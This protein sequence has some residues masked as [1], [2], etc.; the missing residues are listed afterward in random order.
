[1]GVI[2][3]FWR[4]LKSGGEL[5]RDVLEASRMPFWKLAARISRFEEPFG[6]LRDVDAVFGPQARFVLDRLL[7]GDAAAVEARDALIRAKLGHLLQTPTGDDDATYQEYVRTHADG[8]MQV[9]K[10]RYPYLAPRTEMTEEDF[11]AEPRIDDILDS[12]VLRTL[13]EFGFSIK[14][15][16][17]GREHWSC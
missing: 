6:H 9:M 3:W 10:E 17:K 1:M 4:R 7:A 16:S 8:I 11:E 13:R 12:V 15:R 5:P 2:D 14:R